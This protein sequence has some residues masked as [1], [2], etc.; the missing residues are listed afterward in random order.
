MLR[1]LFSSS[2][3]NVARS[4]PSRARACL[5]LA[6][7]SCLHA[8][9]DHGSSNASRSATQVVVAG[10]RREAQLV[11]ELAR[12]G[13]ILF[14]GTQSKD[15]SKLEK[16][17]HKALSLLTDIPPQLPVDSE[18][19]WQ[20]R[21]QLVWAKAYLR[22]NEGMTSV[23][24]EFAEMIALDP[25]QVPIGSIV[26]IARVLTRQE[27]TT[28]ARQ[29]LTDYLPKLGESETSTAATVKSVVDRPDSK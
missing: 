27:R 2:Q 26:E 9:D 5:A 10:S 4:R 1:A 28:E 15:P 14:D 24:Q 22:S 20:A 8:C 6:M 17:A 7:L 11:K 29:L 23:H 21:W 3:R 16:A 18:L 25:K 19:Y 13:E 12:A